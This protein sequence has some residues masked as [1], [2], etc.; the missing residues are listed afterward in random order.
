R[1]WLAVDRLFSLQGVGTVV[2]GTLTRGSLREGDIVYAASETGVLETACRGLE[3]HGCRMTEVAAPSRV[4]INLAR[5]SL[6]DISRGDVIT[7][8]PELIVSRRF[9]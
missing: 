8:D 9:D 6:E 3:V 7:K 2:T 4:A 5:L 1:A